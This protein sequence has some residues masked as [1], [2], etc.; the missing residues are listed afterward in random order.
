MDL[1]QWMVD[2]VTVHPV[3]GRTEYGDAEDGTPYDIAA[4]IEPGRQRER[5]V[6]GGGVDEVS[7]FVFWTLAEVDRTMRFELDGEVREAQLIQSTHDKQG[8]QT[9]YKVQI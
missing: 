4:R 1:R 2:T 9:L 5:A 6:R 7:R 8:D 3:T